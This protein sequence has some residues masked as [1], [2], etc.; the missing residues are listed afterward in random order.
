MKKIHWLI[1]LLIISL[2]ATTL[3]LKNTPFMV[4]LKTM[5]RGIQNSTNFS[6]QQVESIEKI[7]HSYLMNN[8]EIL[9]EMDKKIREQ[10]AAKQKARLERI[11]A[12]I[13]KYRNEIFDAQ[14]PGRIILGNP[15][16]EITI[17]EFTQHQCP[18][19]KRS[20]TILNDIIKIH[21]EIRIIAIYWPFL[22]AD[23]AYAAKAVMAAQKQNKAKLMDDLICNHHRTL[24]K[25]QLDQLLAEQSE[26]DQKTL[27]DG[28]QDSSLD[29]ALVANFNLA[30]NLEISGTPTFIVANK[31]L[32]KI[33]LIPEYTN[34]CK[35]ELMDAINDVK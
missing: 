17:V 32:T 4:K 23:A 28:M 12:N 31:A 13:I 20:T 18:A 8:P 5:R 35:Q 26:L 21:P 22:G 29:K 27:L 9:L 30:K 6:S 24:D 25:A 19:C 3:L 34:N 14:L 1:L 2:G 7:V 15:E 11:K 10:E 33:T 16:G